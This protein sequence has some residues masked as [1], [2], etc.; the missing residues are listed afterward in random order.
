MNVK[1]MLIHLSCISPE[2][3]EE[4]SLRSL[5]ILFVAQ[6]N[7]AITAHGN[8]K[9]ERNDMKIHPSGVTSTFKI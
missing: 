4:V 2:E 9:A 1:Q 5:S 7:F 6:Q 8:T 3:I